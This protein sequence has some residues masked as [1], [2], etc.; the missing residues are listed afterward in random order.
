MK[1]VLV[2]IFISFFVQAQDKKNKHGDLAL[3]NKGI[4]IYELVYEDLDLNDRIN[5]LDSLPENIRLKEEAIELKD[6]ILERSLE[7]F[8]EMI[9][10]YPKSKLFYMALNN[11]AQIEFELKDFTAARETYLAIL[12]SKANDKDFGGIGSGIMIEPYANYKNRAAR[13]LS[14]I[15]YNLKNYKK[16]IEYLD[17][18]KKYPYL[19]FCGNEIASDKI[20]M[21]TRYALNYI[22]LNDRKTAL[23][24]LLPQIM[25]TGLASNTELVL[26]AVKTFK[27]EYGDENARV[28][29]DKIKNTLFSKKVEQGD[30]DYDI[31]FI[32]FEGNT[33]E[34]ETPYYIYMPDTKDETVRMAEAINKSSFNKLLNE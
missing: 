7:Y 30:A 3:F 5:S 23:T 2:F 16:S 34:L 11:K 29:F 17:L 10:L 6:N 32:V 28:I 14:V 27:E 26:L 12:H 13:R 19:H 31:Y 25:E 33:I 20:Y 24:Y 15:E 18:T 22:A 8:N 1:K 21:A 9:E 4:A